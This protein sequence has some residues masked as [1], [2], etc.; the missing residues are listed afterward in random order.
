MGYDFFLD[1]NRLNST[2]IAADFFDLSSDLAQFDGQFDILYA[3][4][5]LHLFG[6][7]QQ[8]TAC[9]RMVSLLRP[10]P[11]ALLVGRQIGSSIP[12]EYRHQAGDE[13]IMYRHDI[14]SFKRMWK[15]IE[16][17]TDTE[18]DVEGVLR[19]IEMPGPLAAHNNPT[20]SSRVVKRLYFTVRR[21]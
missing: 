14:A 20:W 4:S 11:G 8:V 7:S 6:W 15:L 19:A 12:G 9:K 13:G 17:E 18:W 21:K 10:T 3:G 2:F 16:K 1:R 5:F